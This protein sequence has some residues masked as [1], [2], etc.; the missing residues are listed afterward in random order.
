MRKMI[1]NEG[2]KLPEEI[3]NQIREAASRPIVYDEDCPPQTQE[4]LKRFKRVSPIS[5]VTAEA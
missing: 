1:F 3:I 4:Q 2:D 5:P